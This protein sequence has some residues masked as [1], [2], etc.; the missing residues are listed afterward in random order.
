MPCK[1]V[2][3]DVS[4]DILNAVS[5]CRECVVRVDKDNK[6]LD[7]DMREKPS[8]QRSITCSHCMSTFFD[9]FVQFEVFKVSPRN[10]AVMATK[11]KLLCLYPGPAIWVPMDIFM[12][13]C[14]FQELSS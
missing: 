3:R 1:Q 2:T 8:D 6:S 10:I 12:N 14:F 13:E 7:M 4:G 9:D 5:I 11:G